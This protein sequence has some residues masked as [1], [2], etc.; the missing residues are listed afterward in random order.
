MV[1][2]HASIIKKYNDF[3]LSAVQH[4]DT[5]KVKVSYIIFGWNLEGAACFPEHDKK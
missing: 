4:N 1:F 3:P 2:F 5:L